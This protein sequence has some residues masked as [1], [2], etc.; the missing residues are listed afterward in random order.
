M[1]IYDVERDIEEE[2]DV[3]K[4]RYDKH[5]FFFVHI[6]GTDSAGEDGDF[7]RKVDVIQKADTVL[8]RMEELKPDVIIVT[9]DHS[10]P[11]LLKGHSWHPV[12]CL[13]HSRYC[14][15]DK[16]TEFSEFAC[17]SGSLGRFSA[18]NIMP[19]AMANALKLNKY[20]A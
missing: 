5:D 2:L 19:I 16:V 11:A 1:E 4:D 10:T 14:R 15:P 18:L 8:S 13:I 3:L 7:K 17:S 6:K 20:G 12:P 9:G